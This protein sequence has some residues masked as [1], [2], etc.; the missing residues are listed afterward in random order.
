MDVSKR[1]DDPVNI[2]PWRWRQRVQ[3][4]NSNNL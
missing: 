1:P 4:P 2:L 3:I